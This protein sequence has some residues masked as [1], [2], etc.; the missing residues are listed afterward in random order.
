MY[1]KDYQISPSHNEEAFDYGD[2][3]K[4]E[5]VQDIKKNFHF[6]YVFMM[7]ALDIFAPLLGESTIQW[8]FGEIV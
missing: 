8:P 4:V 1:F 3:Q 5:R 6:C 2:E 7:H